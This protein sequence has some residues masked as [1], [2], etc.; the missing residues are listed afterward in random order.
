MWYK[1][2]FAVLTHRCRPNCCDIADLAVVDLDIGPY[3]GKTQQQKQLVCSSCPEA[4]LSSRVRKEVQLGRL[5]SSPLSRSG[6]LSHF[7]T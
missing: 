1:F 2:P 5:S 6:V 3:N 7:S 4:I